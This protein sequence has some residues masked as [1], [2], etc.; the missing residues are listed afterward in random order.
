MAPLAGLLAAWALAVASGLTAQRASPPRGSRGAGAALVARRDAAMR[1]RA[2]DEG[3][4]GF[5][6]LRLR[7][8]ADDARGLAADSRRAPFLSRLSQPAATAAN[9]D[10]RGALDNVTSTVL[11]HVALR[12]PRSE[13]DAV[14]A[15]L[16]SLTA[17][18]TD[19]G[20]A[21]YL[22]ALDA[23]LSGVR[24]E[25]EAD[26]SPVVGLTY[27]NFCSGLEPQMRAL[28]G[29]RIY[30]DAFSRL[31]AEV[32]LAALD[33]DF[34]LSLRDRV[35]STPSETT[36]LN[37]LSN[38]LLRAATFG[39][40]ADVRSTSR[41]LQ[42]RRKTFS[43]R[44]APAK[45][46]AAAPN[47]F[48]A[49]SSA[50]NP[51]PSAAVAPSREQAALAYL[52]ALTQ[53][54]LSAEELAAEASRAKVVSASFATFFRD[55][56]DASEGSAAPLAQRLGDAY[57]VALQR[58]LGELTRRNAIAGVGAV[59]P[60][61]AQAAAP[62]QGAPSVQ[63][64]TASNG[65]VTARLQQS[66]NFVEW[67]MRIRRELAV[68]RRD[69]G[70]A[71]ENSLQPDDF[72]GTWKLQLVDDD[73]VSNNAL[74]QP[75][76]IT[77]VFDS[78]GA[79]GLDVKFEPDGGV[80]SGGAAASTAVDR[81]QWRVRPGPAHLDTCE[82]DVDVAGLGRV[83]FCGYVDRGQRIESRFSR[84]PIRVSGFAF[85]RQQDA[86]EDR[87]S[88]RFAM[89]GPVDTKRAVF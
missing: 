36:E 43:E 39:S 22:G 62:S 40:A 24:P 79:Q 68:K 66:F 7:V 3:A 28:T 88:G 48:A 26:F 70:I 64:S 54:S 37:A 46:P 13:N 2:A 30:A 73:V 14:R 21:A 10:L 47:F 71:S 9:D 18:A 5:A 85:D 77:S 61:A 69:L 87:P 45:E 31:V 52:D 20:A 1:A 75:L 33:V 4:G 15:T 63:G 49:L 27:S 83:A 81:A 56:V 86:S 74:A 29:W 23:L 57:A 11:R 38:A 44:W 41:A 35:S 72:V 65:S 67:E 34:C 58:F 51:A 55:G 84:R 59:V 82:F 50:F 32:E 78:Q 60:T 19:G 42:S 6:A 76:A 25:E 8:V 16:A 89:S 53:L 80:V 12:R 17:S